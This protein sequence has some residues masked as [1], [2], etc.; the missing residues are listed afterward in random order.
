MHIWGETGLGEKDEMT[1]SE[2]DKHQE[3]DRK[4]METVIR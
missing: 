1:E 4:Q 2:T 3:R